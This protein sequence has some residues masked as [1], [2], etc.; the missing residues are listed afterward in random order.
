VHLKSAYFLLIGSLFICFF[1]SCS[2]K[3]EAVLNPDGSGSAEFRFEVKEFFIDSL[4]EMASFGDEEELFENGNF[5]NVEKTKQSFLEKPSVKLLALESPAPN[6]LEGSFTFQDVEKVFQEEAELLEAGILTFTRMNGK[7]IL[8]LH[9][10]KQNFRQVT[11]FS[12]ALDNPLFEMFGP[13]ENDAT[14]KQDYYEMI[15]FAFGEEGAEGLKVSTVDLEITVT[16]E[17]ISQRGGKKIDENTVLFSIP[18]IDIL[19][20]NNTLDYTIEFK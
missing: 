12:E 2:I 19:L 7:N 10:D 1:C 8:H 11:S 18:L 15:E 9:L 6:I 20:L 16:G 13:Q 14:S 5:F 17:L 4:M 3:Q